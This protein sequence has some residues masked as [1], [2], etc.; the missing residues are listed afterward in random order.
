ML[1]GCSTRYLGWVLLQLLLDI[2]CFTRICTHVCLNLGMFVVHH[3]R[4]YQGGLFQLYRKKRCRCSD[5]FTLIRNNDFLKMKP[6]GPGAFWTKAVI[7]QINCS[8][9]FLFVCID[10][11]THV[12]AFSGLAISSI[13]AKRQEAFHAAFMR[14]FL[15]PFTNAWKVEEEKT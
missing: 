5:G 13:T 1:E 6:Q 7:S 8:L 3:N 11:H 4:G 15:L 9:F 12:I 2:N 14:A 10:S